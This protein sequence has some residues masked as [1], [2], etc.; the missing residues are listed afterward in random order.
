MGEVTSAEQT[1]VWCVD[2]NGAMQTWV[3][4]KEN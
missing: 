1:L 2:N 3:G 4:M